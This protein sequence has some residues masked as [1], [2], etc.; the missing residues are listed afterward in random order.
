MKAWIKSL[1]SAQGSCFF[2]T[3]A[4]NDSIEQSLIKESYDLML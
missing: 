1:Q 2:Q 3:V 4:T